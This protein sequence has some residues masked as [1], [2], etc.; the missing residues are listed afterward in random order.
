MCSEDD[1]HIVLRPSNTH[2]IDVIPQTQMYFKIDVENR[3][4]GGHLHVK[5]APDQ[6]VREPD[7]SQKLK[8]KKLKQLEP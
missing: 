5:Y 1:F 4:P 8:Q 7:P 3:E 2:T 6:C